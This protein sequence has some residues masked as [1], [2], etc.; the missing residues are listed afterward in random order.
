MT[1]VGTIVS[2]VSDGVGVHRAHEEGD[3]LELLG[4]DASMV[5]LFQI[6]SGFALDGLDL[7]RCEIG[8]VRLVTR[9][10]APPILMR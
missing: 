7:A 9:P 6:R 1:R 8:S 3:L 2:G 5:H 4:E 10:S